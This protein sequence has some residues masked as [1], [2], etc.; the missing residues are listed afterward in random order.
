MQ[1]TIVHVT[2]PDDDARMGETPTGRLARRWVN[3]R[4]ARGEITAATAKRHRETLRHFVASVGPLPV[5]RLQR[6]HIERWLATRSHVAPATRRSDFSVVRCFTRWLVMQQSVKRDPTMGMSAPRAPRRVVRTL[7]DD[8]LARLRAVLPDA[9]A[10]A[11]VALML[12]LGLRRA[13]VVGLQLGDWD[14]AAGVLYVVGKGGH[15]RMLPVPRSVAGELDAYLRQWPA[16]AGPLVRSLRDGRSPITA[17]RLGHLV[18]IWIA[19]A[20]VKQH[21]FDGRSAHALRRTL[22]SEVA[23]VEPDLRVV[24]AILGHAHLATTE[25]YLREKRDLGRMRSALEAAS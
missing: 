18:A 7:S 11:V 24:Q 3:E 1:R 13:E 8:E 10:H 22:A 14:R 2:P 12:G 9:R 5:E 4:R 21:A 19:Q 25:V 17:N 16:T 23:D 15:T 6:R 20:G